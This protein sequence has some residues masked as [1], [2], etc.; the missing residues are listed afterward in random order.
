MSRH[1]GNFDQS[2][3]WR[4]RFSAISRYK[5]AYR[6]KVSLALECCLGKKVGSAALKKREASQGVISYTTP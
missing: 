1:L 4:K 3:R 6:Q 5:H 2:A